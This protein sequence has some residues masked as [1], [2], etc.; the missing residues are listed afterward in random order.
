MVA[1]VG[2]GLAP[3]A[4]AEQLGIT[5]ETARTALK[6][7]FSKVGVSRQSERVALLTNSCRADFNCPRP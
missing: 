3:R 4:T 6:R 1:L 5:E 7:V 2:S